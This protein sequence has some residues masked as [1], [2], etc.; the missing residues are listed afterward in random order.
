MY[1]NFVPRL[2][3]LLSVKGITQ[4]QFI[5][6]MSLSQN[7]IT[8]WRNGQTPNIEVMYNIAEYFGISIDYLAGKETVTSVT[9]N[10]LLKDFHSLKKEYQDI[11][12]ANIKMLKELS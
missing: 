12:L 5:S 3:E 7:V 2:E 8:K 11:I 10:Q 9:D 6:E 4:K 1:T